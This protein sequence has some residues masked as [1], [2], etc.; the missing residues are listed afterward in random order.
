MQL[1]VA[2]QLPHNHRI[3]KQ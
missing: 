2:K 1:F 3:I